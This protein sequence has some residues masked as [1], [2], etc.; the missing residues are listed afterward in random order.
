MVSNHMFE[1]VQEVVMLMLGALMVV[2]L[3][4]GAPIGILA[5]LVILLLILAGFERPGFIGGPEKVRFSLRS[6]APGI[7]GGQCT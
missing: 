1:R 7:A 2:G 5:V 4:L 3:V 6:S